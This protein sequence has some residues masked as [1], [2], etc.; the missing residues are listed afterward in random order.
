MLTVKAYAK[1]NLALDV[2]FKRPDGYHEVNMV[3]QSIG[4]ADTVT[5][6]AGREDIA[7]T[8][9]VPNLACNSTNLAYRAA[10]ML[11]D[12]LQ[13]RAGAAIHLHKEIPLAAGLAGGSSNAAAVLAGLNRLW[14]LGLSQEE[15]MTIGAAL[16]SDVPFCLAGGTMRAYGRGELLERL[17]PLPPCYVVLAKPPV[18]VSTAWVYSQYRAENVACHPDIK[19]M[20][21]CLAAGD[22]G[23]VAARLGNVL[24]SVTLPAHPEVARIKESMLAGGAAALMSGS[25]PTVFGL[26]TDGREAVQLA[27]QLKDETGAE[28]FTVQ[29]VA[30]VEW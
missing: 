15:L 19:G 12:K 14:Q 7:V 13:V 11:R 4:L 20:T 29:T 17:P 10:A 3:M 18:G 26:L 22:Y 27:G 6:T 8:C 30:E 16:G 24:E 28:V 9:N 23:G 5:L 2:L 1:I 21:A 25:G